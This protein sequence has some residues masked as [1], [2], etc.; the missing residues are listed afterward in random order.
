MSAH[1]VAEDD[2]ILKAASAKDIVLKI[3]HT[4]DGPPSEKPPP[5]VGLYDISISLKLKERVNERRD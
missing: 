2:K 5:R 1:V 3:W 4:K